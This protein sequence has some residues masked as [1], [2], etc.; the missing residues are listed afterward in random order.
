MEERTVHSTDDDSDGATGGQPWRAALLVEYEGTRYAGFQLQVEDPTIQGELEQALAKFTGQG[1]RVRG[2]SRTDSGAHAKGQVVDFLTSTQHPLEKFA[3][4]MN[5]HLPEDIN[6]L[7]AYRVDQDF[8]SRRCALS[9]TYQYSILNRLSPSPLRRLT[10]LWVR[11]PLD[12]AR[13]NEAAQLLVGTHDF[14]SLA[15]GHPED[16]TA[17]RNVMRWDVTR[18]GD[19]VVIE[20]EANGFMKQQIRKSNG[21]LVEIGRGKYP[22]EKITQALEGNP[23]ETPLLSAHGLCL[24]SVKYPSSTR[25]GPE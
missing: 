4:A 3:P 21:I 25:F 12:V 16:R 6:V 20:C 23:G 18:N 1:S 8:N 13:M 11:E 5:F 22:V 7:E 17:V 9:R 24:I 2:A 14:R 15:V 10:H 19:T